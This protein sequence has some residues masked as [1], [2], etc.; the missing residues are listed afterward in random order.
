MNKFALTFYPLRSAMSGLGRDC[1]KAGEPIITALIVDKDTLRCSPGFFDEFHV[2]DDALERE[3]CYAYWTSQP[4]DAEPQTQ[5][6]PGTAAPPA[7]GPAEAPTSGPDDDFAQR[8][9]RFSLVQVRPEQPA[10]RAAVFRAY[11]GR[12]AISGCAV[13]EALEA[14][15]LFGRDWKDGHNSA[16]D[17]IL[18]RRDLHTLYDRG[19]LRILEDSRVALSEGLEEFYGEF[20]GAGVASPG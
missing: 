2:D 10:F 6:A 7:G 19:L 15:H 8:M 20:E 12:C 9:A 3:R 5:M 13:P 1:V 14:A 11:G 18:L 17:G 4:A 16:A